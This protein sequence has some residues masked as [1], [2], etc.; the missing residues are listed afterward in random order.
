MRQKCVIII[1]SNSVWRTG[2]LEAVVTQ[3]MCWRT[4]VEV[5]FTWLGRG[6]FL[7]YQQ[8]FN[9]RRMSRYPWL[10]SQGSFAP[11]AASNWPVDRTTFLAVQEINLCFLGAMAPF[12]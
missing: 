4:W 9:H 2:S 12:L 6:Y 7:V 3:V 1:M 10:V 8:N 11:R 5:K